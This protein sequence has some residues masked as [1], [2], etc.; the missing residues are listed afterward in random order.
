MIVLIIVYCLF[1]SYFCAGAVVQVQ[2]YKVLLFVFL[3]HC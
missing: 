2:P 1:C 3:V